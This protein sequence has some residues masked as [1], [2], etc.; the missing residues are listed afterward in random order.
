MKLRKLVSVLSPGDFVSISFLLILTVL[1]L[2]FHAR[3]QQWL[4]LVAVN[5]G[6]IVVIG[7]LA[8]A[9]ERKKTKFLIGLHRWY[10]YAIIIFI[11]KELYLMVH[12]IHPTDYDSVF[13]AIDHWLFGVNPT[14][15]FAQYAHP[16]ITE[17]LQVAYFSYY[18]LFI[19][20]GVEV[21]RRYAIEEFDKASFF[22]VYGFYLSYIGYFSLPGVGPRFT[23]HDFSALNTELPGIF[24]TNILRE[25][26]NIGESLP[27][28]HPNPVEIVQRDVFPSGHTQLTIVVMVLALRYRLKTRWL[29]TVL[30]TLLII[31]TVYLR[32]HYVVDLLAGALLAWFTFWSGGKL[33]AWWRGVTRRWGGE[34]VT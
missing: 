1:N 15:W 25:I 24:L 11:F 9:A 23:L 28:A 10:C 4:Y 8:W 2:V 3:V 26:I 31:G 34:F 27:D 7:A 33:A 30:G 18:I 22:V 12:P 14:E 32:Y 19:I 20:L 6:V 29:L 16:V 13:I 21:Y 17:I 5:V